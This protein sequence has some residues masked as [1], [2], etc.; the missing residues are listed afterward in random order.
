M[1]SFI[2]CLVYLVAIGVISFILGR[3]VPK[4]WFCYD[5]FPFH[6][7]NPQKENDLY[8]ALKVRKWKEKL[9]DMS[10]ILPNIMPSKKL[11]TTITSEQLELMVQETCVAEAIHW[12]LSI[13]GFGCV[14]IWKKAGGWI[15]SSLYGLGNLLF[16]I[17]QRHNRPKLLRLLEILR[18]R[19]VVS[20]AIYRSQL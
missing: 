6:S 17:I 4:R 13:L 11:P 3:V 7:K 15:I 18:E 8:N 5:K 12:F 19:E 16:V 1:S 2:K 20:A 10:T 9:P 14:S